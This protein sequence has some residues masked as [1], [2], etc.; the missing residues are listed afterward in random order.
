[1]ATIAAH[2]F[3]SAFVA[4]STAAAGAQAYQAGKVKKSPS[5]PTILT[6]SPTEIKEEE[7]KEKEKTRIRR[8]AVQST[9]LTSARGILEPATVKRK[10]LLGE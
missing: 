4:A 9:I 10:V 6:P 8:G 7:V 3:I 1:M 2:P 5:I